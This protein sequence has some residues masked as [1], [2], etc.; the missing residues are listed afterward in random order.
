MNFPRIVLASNVLA[1]AGFAIMLGV[2]PERL[3]GVGLIVDNPLGRA[4]V[5]AFY[6]GLELGIAGFLA[7]CAMAPS[8]V[9]TGLVCALAVLGATGLGRL[10]GVALEGFETNT[11]MWIFIALELSGAT[12]NAVALRRCPP[13]PRPAS[14]NP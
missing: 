13:S 5:R 2:W 14:S 3:D 4:E 10:T 6:G 7:W 1:W 9:R 12:L 11:M 8:R